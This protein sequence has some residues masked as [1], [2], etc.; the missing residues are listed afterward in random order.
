M[1]YIFLS[2]YADIAA[3]QLQLCPVCSSVEIWSEE[4]RVTED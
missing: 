4:G 1:I 3:V 2:P